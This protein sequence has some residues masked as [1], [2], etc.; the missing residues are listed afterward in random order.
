[1]FENEEYE[2]AEELFENEDWKAVSNYRIGDY[3]KAKEI[4]QNKQDETS[5]YNMG[6]ALAL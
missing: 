4:W 3:Q 5:F 2:K 6:N 1:M